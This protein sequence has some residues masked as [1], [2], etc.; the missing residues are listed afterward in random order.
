MIEERNLPFL[1]EKT[2]MGVRLRESVIESNMDDDVL[3]DDELAQGAKRMLNRCLK[4]AINEF[5]NNPQSAKL[6][7]NLNSF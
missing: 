3:T 5:V 6:I 2:E 1:S 4:E 7:T